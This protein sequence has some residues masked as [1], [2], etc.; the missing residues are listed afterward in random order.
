MAL[1][2][3]AP[4]RQPTHILDAPGKP[5]ALA[6]ELFEAQQSRTAESFADTRMCGVGR[7]VRE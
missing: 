5:V 4:A 7:D 3:G 1:V 6:L 2:L